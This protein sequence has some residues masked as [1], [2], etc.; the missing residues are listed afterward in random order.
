MHGSETAEKSQPSIEAIQQRWCI[1][2]L[3]IITAS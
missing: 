2:A 3:I 1:N